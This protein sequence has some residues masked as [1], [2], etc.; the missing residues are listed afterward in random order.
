MLT[1]WA[2]PSE[3]IDH[4]NDIT[5]LSNEPEFTPRDT[6]EGAPID[7]DRVMEAMEQGDDGM[8]DKEEAIQQIFD[9]ISLP[10]GCSNGD[11]EV[12]CMCV[13]EGETLQSLDIDLHSSRLDYVSNDQTTDLDALQTRHDDVQRIIDEENTPQSWLQEW[14]EDL[15]SIFEDDTAIISWLQEWPAEV[16][17]LFSGHEGKLPVVVLNAETIIRGLT[18]L[19]TSTVAQTIFSVL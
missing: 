10:G 6:Q 16:I 3:A 12:E 18:P 8:F 5:P 17:R 11:C 4:S 19:L 9:Q 13:A 2:R 1:I 15:H 7:E 14:P